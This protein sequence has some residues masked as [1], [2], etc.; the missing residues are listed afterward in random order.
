[1]KYTTNHTITKQE[2]DQQYFVKPSLEKKQKKALKNST[3]V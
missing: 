2:I 1:M 3:F